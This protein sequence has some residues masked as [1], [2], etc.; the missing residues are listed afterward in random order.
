[1]DRSEATINIPLKKQCSNNLVVPEQESPLGYNIEDIFDSFTFYLHQ[2]EVS[3]KKF[4]KVKENDGTLRDIIDDEVLF[5]RTDEDLMMVAEASIALNQA[6]I[7]NISLINERINEEE[8]I[9]NK[10]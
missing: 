6:N 9:K 7:L 4:K 1:M 3:R 5:E 2:R 10:L 8:S